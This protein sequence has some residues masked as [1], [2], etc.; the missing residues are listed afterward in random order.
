MSR[1]GVSLRLLENEDCLSFELFSPQLLELVSFN[2][3]GG[4]RTEDLSLV[5]EDDFGGS[6][7][8]ACF[9]EIS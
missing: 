3:I 4:L 6:E 7:R 5:A 1:R 9:L 2:A 8:G